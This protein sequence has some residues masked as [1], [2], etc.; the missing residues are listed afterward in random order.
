M[1]MWVCIHRSERN[2]ELNVNKA[3]LSWISAIQQQQHPEQRHRLDIYCK[4]VCQYLCHK[5]VLLCPA[6]LALLFV[7]SAHFKKKKVLHIL[8]SG[9]LTAQNIVGISQSECCC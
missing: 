2:N 1:C 7:V 6:L 4:Y 8:M 3:V 5:T 9:I